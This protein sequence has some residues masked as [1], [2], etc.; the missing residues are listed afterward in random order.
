MSNINVGCEAFI[1]KDDQLLLGLRGNVYGKGTWALPGGHLE[2]GEH[3]HEAI[4]RELKEE[5]NIVVSEPNLIAVCNDIQEDTGQHYIH[6]TFAVDIADQEPE[7][8]EPECCAEWKWFPL[9]ELP[10]KLF[11][12]H[13]VIFKALKEKKLYNYR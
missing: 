7:L 2:F 12:P 13:T 11:P 4:I 10:E 5:M 1:T 3:P 9:T 8:C 6:M